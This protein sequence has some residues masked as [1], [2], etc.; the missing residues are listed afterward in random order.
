MY[1]YL[2]EHVPVHCVKMELRRG[3]CYVQYS[4]L[5]MY[6]VQCTCSKLLMKRLSCRVA[7]EHCQY[8]IKKTHHHGPICTLLKKFWRISLN[9]TVDAIA[10]L[11]E[12]KSFVK[13]EG[14]ERQVSYIELSI[15]IVS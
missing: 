15:S 4:V 12:M 13:I 7:D 8:I 9:M 2:I 1:K 10:K 11:Y 5:P 3:G 6:I 14:N